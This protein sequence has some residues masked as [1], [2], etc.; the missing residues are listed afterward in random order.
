MKS[1][2]RASTS[3]GV[4][5][6]ATHVISRSQMAQLSETRSPQGIAAVVPLL[7]AAPPRAR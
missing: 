2:S 4:A 3:T 6:F 5:H 1:I 7:L